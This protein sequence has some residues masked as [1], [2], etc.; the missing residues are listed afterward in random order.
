MSAFV[1]PA[2]AIALRAASACNSMPD[3]SG[4]TPSCVVSA[5]PTI[6]T[7]PLGDVIAPPV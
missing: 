3:M 5:A 4:I 2:S 1:S 7:L 6:A